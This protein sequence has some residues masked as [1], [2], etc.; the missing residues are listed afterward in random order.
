MR[1]GYADLP[2]APTRPRQEES[3]WWRFFQNVSQYLSYPFTREGNVAEG[4]DSYETRRAQ[5]ERQRETI[6]A[7]WK[8][9]RRFFP[10]APTHSRYYPERLGRLVLSL[11]D[12]TLETLEPLKGLGL[13]AL[14]TSHL[15]LTTDQWK[16]LPQSFHMD[17][18]HKWPGHEGFLHALR[19]GH[20]RATAEEA[21]AMS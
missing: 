18:P 7:S 16:N 3:I 12:C 10:Y 21:E 19:D 6:E 20:D 13:S 8:E 5:W 15:A 14:N 9:H 4:T 1:R 17:L 2:P 11:V